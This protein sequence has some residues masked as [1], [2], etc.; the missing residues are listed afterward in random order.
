MDWKFFIGEWKS[1]KKFD[2]LNYNSNFEN[3]INATACNGYFK[4]IVNYHED[5]N[6]YSSEVHIPVTYYVD[7]VLEPNQS[8]ALN[9]TSYYKIYQGRFALKKKTI[10]IWQNENDPIRIK[11]SIK[12][13]L[14]TL[15][16]FATD[17]NF[18]PLADI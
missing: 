18:L 13:N 15:K 11:Y 6:E 9:R 16:L 14:L 1:T 8:K 5:S 3:W 7:F 10:Q 12:N 17:I 4:F 2:P